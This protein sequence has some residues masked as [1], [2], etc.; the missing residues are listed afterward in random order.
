MKNISIVVPIYNME[1]YLRQ[2][3]DS[4]YVQIDN[5]M[6]VI[7][8]NDGSTDASPQICME[9]VEQYSETILINKENGGL[10][11]ARNAGMNVATGEYTYF[12]DSD[13]WLAPNAIR[14]LYNYAIEQHCEVVQGGFYYA[15]ENHLEYDNRWKIDEN[16]HP[17]TLTKHEAMKELVKQQYIKNFAWGKLYKTDLIR[18][19]PF[20]VGVNLEDA[21]WQHRVIDKAERYGVVS[22]PLYY[23]RQRPDSISASLSF[24]HLNLM[25]GHEERLLFFQEHYPDLVLP[26]AAS[27]WRQSLG[28]HEMAQHTPNNEVREAFEEFWQKI[29]RDYYHHFDKALR[30]SVTY[31]LVKR[32]PSSAFVCLSVRRVYDHFFAQRLKIIPVDNG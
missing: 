7:L 23:Y 5:T 21:F 31:Q 12:I 30:H 13:D 9:Y 19:I 1:A 24:G 15:F 26:M 28:F 14:T 3:L 4:L 10:A 8:V 17:F 2:C 16:T 18:Q 22:Q 32:I 27:L 20:R 25:Q 11:D 6:E 29:N